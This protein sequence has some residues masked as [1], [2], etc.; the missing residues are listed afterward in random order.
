MRYREATFARM[1]KKT[2]DLE[3]DDP[4]VEEAIQREYHEV[5]YVLWLKEFDQFHDIPRHCKYKEKEYTEYLESIISYLHNFLLRSQPIINSMRS[6]ATA[7]TKKRSI[8]NISSLS[9]R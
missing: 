5:D 1:R 3:I 6:H 7:S 4:V 2:P 8:Q 9:Y